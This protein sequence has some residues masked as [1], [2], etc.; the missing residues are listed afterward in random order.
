MEEKVPLIFIENVVTE[1]SFQSKYHFFRKRTK[2]GIDLCL[3]IY[4]K[5]LDIRASY[6]RFKRSYRSPCEDG[7]S[8]DGG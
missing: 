1:F 5:L 6:E 8:L 7:A 4:I 2:N 3:K